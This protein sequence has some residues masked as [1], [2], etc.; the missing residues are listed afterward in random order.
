MKRL[1]AIMIT[2][3]VCV[4]CGKNYEEPDGGVYS[5][6]ATPDGQV[7]DSSVDDNG[8]SVDS[9]VPVD[10]GTDLGRGTSQFGQPCVVDNDC[11]SASLVCSSSACKHRTSGLCDVYVTGAPSERLCSS[12]VYN[13]Q[14]VATTFSVRPLT[15]NE[16]PDRWSWCLPRS[17][18]GVLICS[19]AAFF[20]PTCLVDSDCAGHFENPGCYFNTCRTL[21]CPTPLET[22]G[23]Q[24][25]EICSGLHLCVPMD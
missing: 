11:I 14:G 16:V 9:G 6:G 18:D 7:E 5:D 20:S 15:T 12:L 23:C 21:N 8:G 19:S 2:L 17:T 25:G 22:T 13:S 10:L 1:M 4:G 3:L 24:A